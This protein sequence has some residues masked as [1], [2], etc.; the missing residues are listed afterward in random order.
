MCNFSPKYLWQMVLTHYHETAGSNCGWAGLE[1][2]ERAGAPRGQCLI[3]VNRVVGGYGEEASW[4]VRRK[5]R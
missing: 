3:A 4:Q 2:R 5:E 1:A